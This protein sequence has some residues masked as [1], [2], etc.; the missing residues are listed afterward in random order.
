ME[1]LTQLRDERRLSSALQAKPEAEVKV[2]AGQA[3]PADVIVS[4]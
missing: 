1:L 4:K 3:A 2:E